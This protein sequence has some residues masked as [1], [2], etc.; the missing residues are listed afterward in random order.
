M[1]PSEPIDGGKET[2]FEEKLVRIP[3]NWSTREG[4]PLLDNKKG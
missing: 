2:S 3:G 1:V 4:P